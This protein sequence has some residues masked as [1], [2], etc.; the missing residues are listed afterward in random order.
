M[1]HYLPKAVETRGS[2][3]LLHPIKTYISHKPLT[4]NNL[5]LPRPQTLIKNHVVGSPQFYFIAL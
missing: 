1:D 5:I 2:N 3:S 4:S